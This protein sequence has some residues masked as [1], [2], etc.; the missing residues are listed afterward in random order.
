MS[1]I[2]LY[3]QVDAAVAA[4]LPQISGGADG[5]APAKDALHGDVTV[6]AAMVQARAV[7]VA[8]RL[9][10]QGLAEAL[11]ALAGVRSACVAGGGFVNLIFED[12]FIVSA[13]TVDALQPEAQSGRVAVC[14][15]LRAGLRARWT[16]EAAGRL[17]HA[18]GYEVES[19]PFASVGKS[20]GLQALVGS[21]RRFGDASAGELA[22]LEAEFAMLAGAAEAHEQVLFFTRQG[23]GFRPGLYEAAFEALPAG[24]AS[25]AL[26][27]ADIPSGLTE[28]AEQLARLFVLSHRAE[29][30]LDLGD[31]LFLQPEQEN[32][33]F[34]LQYAASKLGGLRAAHDVSDW[35]PETR[36]L[37]LHL[38]YFPRLLALA[39]ELAAPQRLGLFL[40][41][42]SRLLLEAQRAAQKRDEKTICARVIDACEVVFS[43]GFAIVGATPLDEI[44]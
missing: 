27:A 41:E 2:G 16:A 32:P 43:R 39:H 10:A 30:V 4:A 7:G 22:D 5:S 36:R 40:V 23:A 25:T 17:A 19:G 1:R 31:K 35:S 11:G 8:P 15:G 38:A 24:L 26:G 29:R 18:L 34:L 6:T 21:E 13:L 44:T 3:E 9:L 14:T 37:A 42:A 12:R 33:A 28:G 20:A